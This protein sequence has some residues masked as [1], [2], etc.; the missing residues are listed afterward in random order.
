MALGFTGIILLGLISLVLVN[1]YIK[2]DSNTPEL[3][4]TEKSL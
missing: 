1:R 4:G 2:N 3:T